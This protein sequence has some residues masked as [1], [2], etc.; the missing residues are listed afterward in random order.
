MAQISQVE[1]LSR[2]HDLTC[3]DCGTHESLNLWLRKFALQNQANDSARTYVIH[4]ANAV[5]GYYSIAAGS[6]VRESATPRPAQG[7]ARHPVPIALL[8]RLAVHREEQGLGL[9][10]ALL[11]DALFRIERAADILGIRAVLVHAI[12][13][14]ARAFYEKFD[15]EPCLDDEL[16]LMLLMKDLRRELRP[17]P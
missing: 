2:T 7:L 9:G 1:P 14:E 12:D 17:A 13:Q 5:V 16:H 8:G 6:I 3:F 10:T 11:K 15:F 4:R